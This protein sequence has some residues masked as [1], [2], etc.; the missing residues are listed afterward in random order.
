MEEVVSNKLRD[1]EINKDLQKF[2]NDVLLVSYDFNSPY[3]SAEADKDSKW[4]AIE[5]A[6][7]FKKISMTQFVNYSKAV[8]WTK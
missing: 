4:P 6:Y 8:D 3:P 7:P 5:T 1:S 2:F